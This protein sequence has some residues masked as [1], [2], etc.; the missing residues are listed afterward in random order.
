MKK[1]LLLTDNEELLNRFKLF[2]KHPDFLYHYSYSYNNVDFCNKFRS[3]DWFFPL[4]VLEET[5][6]IIR[7]YSVLISLH[8]K[9]VFPEKLVKNIRCINVHPGLNP[10]NRGWF[11]QVFSIIN[12]F[13][14]GATIHEIDKWIDHGPV[15]YQ[16]EVKIELWDTSLSVYNKIIE[17]EMKLLEKNLMNILNHSYSTFIV[18]KGNLNCKKDFDNLCEL[19]LGDIDTFRNHINRLRALSHGDYANAYFYTNNGIKIFLKLDLWKEVCN[20]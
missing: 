8:C 11:P 14:C 18:N 1:L 15:I 2:K 9:Q 10:F 19:D 4:D 12:G 13:R 17:V 5:D 16:E 20:N 7:E 3:S 6:F